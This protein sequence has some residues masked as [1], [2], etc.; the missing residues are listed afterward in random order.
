MSELDR[1]SRLS[2]KLHK[3][4]VPQELDSKNRLENCD[5]RYRNLEARFSEHQ[6]GQL[7]RYNTM[8][9]QAYKLQRQMDKDAEESNEKAEQVFRKLKS[10]QM[11]YLNILNDEALKRNDG[12]SN[13]SRRIDERVNSFK[14]DLGLYHKQKEDEMKELYEFIEVR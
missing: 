12:D 5:L 7:K 2:S 11:E 1:I 14:T 8:K 13:M 9:E 6:E 4:T 10:V 3:L